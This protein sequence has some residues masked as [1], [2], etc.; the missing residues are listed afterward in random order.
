M[1]KELLLGLLESLERDA[2]NAERTDEVYDKHGAK[3][4]AQQSAEL[5]EKYG[6]LFAMIEKQLMGGIDEICDSLRDAITP[7]YWD[8]MPEGIFDYA[9]GRIRA[10]LNTILDLTGEHF[11]NELKKEAETANEED[12]TQS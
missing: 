9:I 12:S 3:L 5:K 1:K 2:Q 11:R 7:L 10:H 8:V 4:L 6:L